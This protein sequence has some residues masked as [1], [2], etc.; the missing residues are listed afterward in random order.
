MS[1]DEKLSELI[2]RIAT[3][4]GMHSRALQQL[5]LATSLLAEFIDEAKILAKEMPPSLESLSRA[6]KNLEEKSQNN[7][8][9]L[10][11][12]ATVVRTIVR[13]VPVKSL[14]K[15]ADESLVNALMIRTNTLGR[16][17]RSHPN[18]QLLLREA[19]ASADRAL[20]II[21]DADYEFNKTMHSEALYFAV[22]AY[23]ELSRKTAAEMGFPEEL[24][25]EDHKS[26]DLHVASMSEELPKAAQYLAQFLEMTEKREEPHIRPL[27]D[28]ICKS[29]IVPPGVAPG[30]A[31]RNLTAAFSLAR[32][33]EDPELFFITG[34]Q[35]AE[36]HR[37]VQQPAAAEE[38]IKELLSLDMSDKARQRLTLSLAGCLSE[39]GRFEEAARLQKSII[40]G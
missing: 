9:L 34:S 2:G 17:S 11:V 22:G 24:F 1:G 12:L 29:L 40:D 20:Q 37:S 8:D 36:H 25:G 14:F 6:L 15:L 13:E 18:R 28:A 21:K 23:Y 26:S 27:V 32:V 3:H 19:A 38:I 31:K 30:I 35:L 33:A 7:I 16:E 5:G 4:P 10:E 39:Q